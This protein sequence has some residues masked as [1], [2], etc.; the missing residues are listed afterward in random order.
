[1]TEMDRL[2]GSGHELLFVVGEKDDIIPAGCVL[3]FVPHE[4]VNRSLLFAPVD[5]EMPNNLHSGHEL[6]EVWVGDEARP[7]GF[8]G[9]KWRTY[10][11]E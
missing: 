11:I 9:K 2:N 3:V 8:E 1:M 6:I 4:A 5:M 10:S 7:E